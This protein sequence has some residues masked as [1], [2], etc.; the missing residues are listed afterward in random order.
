MVRTIVQVTIALPRTLV[1]TPICP[2]KPRNCTRRITIL[3]NQALRIIIWPANALIALGLNELKH[4]GV[5]VG[6]ALLA[7]KL[8]TKYIFVFWR[9]EF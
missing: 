4:P 2:R 1:P 6:V 5:L 8:R 3:A 7:S 9:G